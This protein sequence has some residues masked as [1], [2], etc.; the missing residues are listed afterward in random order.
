MWLYWH[1]RGWCQGRQL[2]GYWRHAIIV[3]AIATA[4]ITPTVEPVNMTLVMGPL[5]TLYFISVAL[6]YTLYKPHENSRFF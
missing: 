1:A 5:M 3:V 4:A 2:L 6:A